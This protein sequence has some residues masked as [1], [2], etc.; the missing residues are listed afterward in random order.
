MGEINQDTIADFLKEN[1]MFFEKGVT[2]NIKFRIKQLK[3]LE[4]AFRTYEN[5]FICALNQD[6]GK[7]EFEAYTTEIGFVYKSLKHMIKNLSNWAKPEKV[8]TPLYLMPSK[9]YIIKEPYGTVLIIGPF[10][11]PLQL[12]M[13]PLIGALAAGNCAVIKPSE[14][15][16]AVS[17][18]FAEMIEK[19]FNKRYIR[20]MEGGIETTSALIHSRFDYI[21]FT[22]SPKVGKI[23][24]A[25][26]AENLIPITLELGGKS[27]VIVEKTAN[28]PLAAKRIV[29]G[30]F[31]NAGQTCVAPDYVLVDSQIKDMLIKHIKNAVLDFFGN[32]PLN[33]PDYGK[34]IDEKQFTRLSAMIDMEKE[35]LLYGGNYVKENLRIEPTLIEVDSKESPVMEDEIFGPLLPIMQYRDLDEAISIINS[36]PKPLAAYLFT[37]SKEAQKYVLRRISFG[38]GCINDTISHIVNPYLPFGGV[39]NSG[40]GFYHGKYSFELFSHKKSLL[41]KTTLIETGLTF[42]PYKNKISFVRRILK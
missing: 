19:N 42:P 17:A 11:Y 4:Y 12:L 21:F 9:S 10:N 14:H 3:K 13:E 33:N 5:K 15:T 26:A 38:G 2:K 30:K 41:K 25:A 32:E 18:V 7:S 16:P 27:P 39:G 29:W 28:I 20:V 36:Y 8:K 24:M 34:V 1:K 23:V 6:L 37:E 40:M 22:G 35:H 31:I